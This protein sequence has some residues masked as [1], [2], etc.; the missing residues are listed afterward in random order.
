MQRALTH[1]TIEALKPLEKRYEVH[2]LRCPGMSMRI[3]CSGRKTFNIK[4]RYGVMD[5]AIER[6]A[7]YQANR[8]LSHVRKFFSIAISCSVRRTK[9]RLAGLHQCA[10]ALLNGHRRLAGV[11]MISG[12]P[13]HPV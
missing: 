10:D 11:C 4:F 13:P 2:D 8:I 1:K 6:G 9:R 3:E 5:A 12:E 7:N